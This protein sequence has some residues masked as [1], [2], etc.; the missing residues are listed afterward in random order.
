MQPE[1]VVVFL[2][3]GITGQYA[4]TLLWDAFW[5]E[6]ERKARAAEI[7]ATEPEPLTPRSGVQC[8]ALRRE[9]QSR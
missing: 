5:R 3:P 9:R 1:F 6:V 7:Q 4:L 2:A 8:E